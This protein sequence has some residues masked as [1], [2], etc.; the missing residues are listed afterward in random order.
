M[1]KLKNNKKKS[2][3]RTSAE[4]GFGE[5]MQYSKSEANKPRFFYLT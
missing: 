5:I 4:D 2:K 1:S 3:K